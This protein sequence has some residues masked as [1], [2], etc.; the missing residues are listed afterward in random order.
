MSIEFN[1]IDQVFHLQTHNSTYQIKID[2]TGILRHLYYGQPVGNMNMEYFSLHRER[3][4][5]GITYEL[6][7]KNTSPDLI[8]QEYSSSGV[9]DYR[10]ASISLS[11]GNGSRSVEFKY[12]H[13]T[14]IPGKYDIPG[15]PSVR[16]KVDDSDT[17][18]ITLE[19]DIC[20]L[21]LKLS[22]GVFPAKDVITRTAT[23]TNTGANSV[24]LEKFAS[25][26]LD[27]MNTKLDL[28]HFPGRHCMERQIERVALG[29]DIHTISSRRG[30]SSHQQNPFLILCSPEAN[31]DFG[32]CYGL[33]LMYS[34]NHKS[35]IE[36]DQAGSTRVVMGIN[37][38]DFRWNLDP[39]ASFHAPEVIISYSPSGLNS[40][41]HNYHRIIKENVCPEKYLNVR[42]PILV[43]NWEA[44]YFDFNTEKILNLAQ[45]AHDLG[46]EML[47]LDDGWFGK[48]DDDDAGLGDWFVNEEKL[49]G[50][51]KLISDQINKIGMKFGLW[52]EPEMVNPD[53]ELYRLHPEWALQDPGRKP[54]LSRNQLVLDMSNQKVQDYLYLCISRILDSATIDYIK[55]DFNRPLSNVYS[56]ASS[57]QCQGET[58]HRFVL[59]TYALLGRLTKNYPDVMIE[60]CAGGGGRFDAGMLYYSPQ[61]WC[62]DNTDPIARL[63]IQKGTSYGYPISTMGS[64]VSASP[65]HQTGR[66]TTL[67]TR[68]VVAMSGTFG[69]ELDLGKLS[70]EEKEAIKLQIK[71]FKRYYWLI[72]NGIYYRLS[73]LAGHKF[74]G[75]WEFVSED[76][77]EALVNYV[78]C[79]VNANSE[80]PC[81]RL[82][83][84]QADAWYLLEGTREKFTGAALMYGGYVF[85]S[86]MGD[87]PAEQLHFIRI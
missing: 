62:S 40:L 14:I 23:I 55:W 75:A 35:Q 29:H 52:F 58:A 87:Y 37:E 32:D 51:L 6:N 44:T 76:R 31:E 56:N 7:D 80:L 81:I 28:L 26:C 33:M 20:S 36:V 43:N 82:K 48:R 86:M 19:D 34:G 12:S 74:Y 18:E 57:S 13:H 66:S 65:N 67:N 41:S 16:G 72:Q 54:T 38:E 39:G 49:P 25:A 30:M 73:S 10:I 21:E 42:R 59:G 85:P 2:K 50:G 78:M 17:L 77:S 63:N 15:L 68:G 45:E 5:S 53:S 11:G 47:V 1:K 64:H 46:I 4:I 24:K 69:Y 9:G 22:Y 61:I 3:S 79:D 8:P 84:L 83:G 70:A 60:G 27:L 71:D